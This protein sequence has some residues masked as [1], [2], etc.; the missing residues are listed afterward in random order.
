MSDNLDG[1]RPRTLH[2]DLFT[3]RQLIRN[4]YPMLD[5]S[6][7]Q[8]WIRW[9][10]PGSWTYLSLIRPLAA[11]KHHGRGIFVPPLYTR[12]IYTNDHDTAQWHHIMFGD[13]VFQLHFC[14]A[15]SLHWKLVCLYFF[16]RHSDW[17]LT[18]ISSYVST[19][20]RAA[21]NWLIPISEVEDLKL[22]NSRLS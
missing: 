8:R 19:S 14:L 17:N 20:R 16:L 13:R 5:I 21:T 7:K 15:V 18:G 11:Q 9:T 4:A 22:R 2:K 10:I 3:E 1:S 6:I 12:H